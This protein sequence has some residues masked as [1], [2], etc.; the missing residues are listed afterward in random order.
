MNKQMKIA[1]FAIIIAG[2]A[3]SS[4]VSTGTI[5]FWALTPNKRWKCWKNRK[6][7][8]YNRIL[9]CKNNTYNNICPIC[10]NAFS[11]Y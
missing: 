10:I 2:G 5:K 6:H 4:E 7:I 8:V 11:C 9:F 3:I 1:I